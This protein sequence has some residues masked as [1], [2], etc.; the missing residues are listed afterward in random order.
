MEFSGTFELDDATVENVWLA[1]SDPAMIQHA[2]PGCELLVRVDEADPDFDALRKRHAGDAPELTADPD[3]IAGRAFEEGATYA[4]LVETSVGSVSPSFETVV[5]IDDREEPSM[6]A[7]GE[8]TAGNSSFEM[9]SWMELSE[10]DDGVAV[11]WSAEADVFG[12]LA[13][14]GQRMINPV[15]NR[16]TKRFFGNLQDQL[17]D[18]EAEA[19][20]DDEEQPEPAV[21]EGAAGSRDGGV[22]LFA[23]LKRLIGIG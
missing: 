13:Q 19:S 5:T 2:L 9:D 20:G 12:R 1:L 3:V 16:M 18:L 23:R 8:G 4:A 6:A 10:T 15:A 17:A 21:E 7:S 22:G 14:M 11:E